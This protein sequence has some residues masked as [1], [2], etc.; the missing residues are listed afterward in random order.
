MR[1]QSSLEYMILV[2]FVTLALSIILLAS[3]FYINFSKDRIKETQVESFASKII[4]SSESVFFSGEPSQTTISL[5]LPAGIESINF[6]EKEVEITY[7][8]SSG[9]NIR[10]FSSKVKISGII[11]PSEGT[12]ILIIKAQSDEVLITQK[13]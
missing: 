10:S 6:N 7:I 2:G 3:Y 9:R 8:T 1:G 4:S 11:N 5:F 12:K 13:Q